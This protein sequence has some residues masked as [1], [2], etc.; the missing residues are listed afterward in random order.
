M[1]KNIIVLYGFFRFFDDLAI[2]VL[3]LCD[4]SIEEPILFGKLLKEIP[5]F[6]VNCLELAS[7]GER[8]SFLACSSVQNHLTK[9]WFGEI[10][11]KD[12]MF[13]KFKVRKF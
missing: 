5:L 6:G 10:T 3:N 9:T 4:L 2:G 13:T 11:N 12:D 1:K 7:I 8:Q